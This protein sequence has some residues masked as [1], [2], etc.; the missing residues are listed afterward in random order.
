[1][2]LT[3]ST[4]NTRNPAPPANTH[5]NVVAI[6][7][8]SEMTVPRD[9]SGERIPK[10]KNDR[11]VSA[12]TA[13]AIASVAS[14]ISNDETFGRM[15]RTM[16]VGPGTPMYFA[17]VTYSRSRTDI[18]RLRTIRAD[19]IQLRAI[20]QK[21]S[22]SARLLLMLRMNRAMI[23]NPGSTSSRSMTHSETR[24]NQPPK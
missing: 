5:G 8:P 9:T 17:A 12:M 20:S 24:S 16:I 11:L 18:V 23:R 4:M 22:Q 19:S 7:A 15:C 6:R 14:M 3:A 2:K 10:P 13:A 1:M 21:A